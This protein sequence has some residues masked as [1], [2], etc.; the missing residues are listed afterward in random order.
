M[1]IAR[2]LNL[3]P[4]QQETTCSI[5]QLH[6]TFDNTWSHHFGLIFIQEA[7]LDENSRDCKLLTTCIDFQGLTPQELDSISMPR[8]SKLKSRIRKLFHFLETLILTNP[9]E[10]NPKK[11]MAVW[12][13]ETYFPHLWGRDRGSQPVRDVVA[14]MWGMCI[15]RA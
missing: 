6:F 3:T 2:R 8:E 13:P 9:W 1:H 5:C 15:Q 11:S 7:S 14:V 4:V 10:L 12:L